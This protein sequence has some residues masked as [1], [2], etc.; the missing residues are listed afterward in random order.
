MRR[1]VSLLVPL[2]LGCML[3]A[4]CERTPETADGA[5]L[6]I[7]E[8]IHANDLDG[9]DEQLR[10]ALARW[11]A[12]WRL[13]ELQG[14][15]DLKRGNGTRAQAAFERAIRERAI[16]ERVNRGSPGN[17]ASFDKPDDSENPD[18][19]GLQVKL[20]RSL[21]EQE[22]FREVLALAVPVESDSRAARAWLQLLRLE[23]ELALRPKDAA[24]RD[25]IDAAS[26]DEMDATIR[27]EA[28]SL[29]RLV[30]PDAEGMADVASRLE[31]LAKREEIV[32]AARK[33]AQCR[34][35][36]EPA[37]SAELDAAPGPILRVGP[38][39]ELRTPGAAAAGAD[40]DCGTPAAEANRPSLDD[41]T[42]GP[43]RP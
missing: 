15:I 19:R 41:G 27:D 9:A 12:D 25:E 23:A 32:K 7:D 21:L 6:A 22:R 34:P 38:A 28:E 31:E 26:R 43:Q 2:V 39:E 36:A 14:D 11:P 20:A 35:S 10:L 29:W 4:G 13:R 17:S 24:S 1:T 16:L 3:L 5:A 40:E 30:F 33:H 18:I 42:A 8:R 37:K